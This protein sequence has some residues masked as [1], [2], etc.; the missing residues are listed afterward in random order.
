M[1]GG[2]ATGTPR[3]YQLVP[4]DRVTRCTGIQVNRVLVPAGGHSTMDDKPVEL[5]DLGEFLR[6]DP[7]MVSNAEDLRRR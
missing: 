3:S 5:P 6:E 2:W 7:Y 4:F 1:S